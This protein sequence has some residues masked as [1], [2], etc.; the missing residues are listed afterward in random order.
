M[1]QH[2]EHKPEQ[3]QAEQNVLGLAVRGVLLFASWLFWAVLLALPTATGMHGTDKINIINSIVFMMIGFSL[4]TAQITAAKSGHT[5]IMFVF[6]F[7]I[8]LLAAWF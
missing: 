5:G 6:A 1:E 3:D 7:G 8:I 2:S 4:C